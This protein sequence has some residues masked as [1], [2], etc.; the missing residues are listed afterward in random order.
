M[1]MRMFFR[2][3]YLA[4]L[5]NSSTRFRNERCGAA[6]WIVIAVAAMS[7]APIG[8]V[9]LS[10]GEERFL[11]SRAGHLKIGQPGIALQQL[12]YD[13][14]RGLHLQFVFLAIGPDTQHPS[15]SSDFLDGQL[16]AEPHLPANGSRF[17]LGR[18]A[19]RDDAAV[20]QH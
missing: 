4:S 9:I 18:S 5:A 15:N 10:E 14:L 12:A 20:L 8:I 17:D 11:Q 6:S 7:V 3:S 13:R 1:G 2:T 16:A 19:L